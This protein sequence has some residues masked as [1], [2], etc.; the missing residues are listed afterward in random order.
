MV[1]HVEHYMERT[2]HLVVYDHLELVRITGETT[3]LRLE[4]P[5]NSE[6]TNKEWNVLFSHMVASLTNYLNKYKE[7]QRQKRFA[8]ASNLMTYNPLTNN[9]KV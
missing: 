7:S 3:T 8:F 2:E 6:E 1:S 5:N 4:K 9:I